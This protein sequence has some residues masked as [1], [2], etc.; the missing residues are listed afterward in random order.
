MQPDAEAAAPGTGEDGQYGTTV[1]STGMSR[2]HG[3]RSLF[4]LHRRH[5]PVLADCI[6]Q[7]RYELVPH[8]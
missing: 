4:T 6:W 7:F 2:R 3:L 1:D 8:F 5:V